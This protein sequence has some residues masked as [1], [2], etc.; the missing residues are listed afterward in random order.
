MVWFAGSRVH[1]TGR[2]V[3]PGRFLGEERKSI[4]GYF[5]N[6]PPPCTPL[7]YQLTLPS[8]LL[9][10]FFSY[11]F[12]SFF[13]SFF[14]SLLE[15]L[16]PWRIKKKKMM[17]KKKKKM[18]KYQIEVKFRSKRKSLSPPPTELYLPKLAII[19]YWIKW[20]RDI[21]IIVLA[22]VFCVRN[23]WPCL[24]TAVHCLCVLCLSIGTSAQ[25]FTHQRHCR[26]ER[27]KDRQRD[28]FNTLVYRF[29]VTDN[30]IQSLQ[31]TLLLGKKKITVL[32][33]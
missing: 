3:L 1:Q 10:L 17:K 6:P 24:P 22:A 2:L 29:T 9:Y 4:K 31:F 33:H 21:I 13:L 8:L 20:Y 19:H 32:R 30:N 14:L 18:K 26:K 23:T 15:K 11:S 7:P 28:M 16:L 27:E 5:L 12:L 25:S